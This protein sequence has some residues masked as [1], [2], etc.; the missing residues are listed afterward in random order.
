MQKL[1]PGLAAGLI[2]AAA[3]AQA[4]AVA[5]PAHDFLGSYTGPHDADLD[6]TSFS[7][8]YESALHQ[9]LIGATLDGSIDPSRAGLY[10]IGVDTG[11]GPVRPFAGLGEPN[12]IFNQAIVVQKT[13]AASV[14]GH[15]LAATISG[16]S[17]QVIVPLAFLPSTGFAPLDY[18]FNL[19]PRDG[20]GA[21]NQISDFAPQ[22]ALM[23]AVPEPAAWALMLAGFG[24]VGATLRRRPAFA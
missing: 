1:L 13:G 9:F 16:D 12:V 17:F 5:D 14:S 8:V 23:T 3:S 11:T 20:L 10:V 7:V 21:N 4:N 15:N 18:G 19:W 2:L 22:N 6:V 24:L